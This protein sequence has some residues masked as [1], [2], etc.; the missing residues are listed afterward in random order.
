MTHQPHPSIN[1]EALPG[2]T[3]AE[4]TAQEIQLELIR[5]WQFNVFDGLDIVKQLVEHQSL[6]QAV[7]MDRLGVANRDGGLPLAG[8]IKLRDLPYNEWN[9]DTLYLLCEN[10]VKANEL[11]QKMNFE[12]LGGMVTI[13]TDRKEVDNA[14]GSGRTEQVIVSVWWD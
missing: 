1:L 13:Y 12:N 3:L 6:W 8:M 11:N 10:I 2:R 9:I 4:A 5:R 14:L 7:F